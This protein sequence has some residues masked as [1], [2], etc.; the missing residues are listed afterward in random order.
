MEINSR[1]QVEHPVTEMV[2]G[3]DL[4]HEQLKVAAGQPLSRTQED[5]RLS[6]VS[7]ECRVNAEDGERGFAPAAGRLDRFTPPGGPFTRVDT[8][9]HAGYLIGTHYDSLLA[10]VVVWAE[11]REQALCR[12]Q[13][14]LSEFDVSGPGVRTTIP[15]LQQVLADPEFRKALHTTALVDRMRSERS[16]G[17]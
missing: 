7:V 9:A 1:I 11:D 6:G 10:K 14:A 13:R 2:T 8:H 5:V 17:I 15:F 16:S 3:V 12:A 4:V